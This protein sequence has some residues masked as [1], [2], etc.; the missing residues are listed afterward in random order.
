MRDG[1]KLYTIIYQPKDNST[2]YPILMERTPSAISPVWRYR[3]TRRSDRAQRGLMKEKYI[4][5]YQDVRG[6]YMSEGVN[7]EVTP[8]QPNKYSHT[9]V[10]E[11]SD[12]YNTVEFVSL[13]TFPTIT[14][15]W[16]YMGSPIQLYATAALPDAH[17]AIRAVSP[18]AHW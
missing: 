7:I 11:S 5:V 1:V 4:F 9:T 13:K 18:Q 15:K 17:P 16:A 10:D 2:A 14:E 12:T 6:R 3:N 8:H